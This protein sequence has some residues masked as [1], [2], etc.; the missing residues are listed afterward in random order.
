MIRNLA[1]PKFSLD[2][3]CE[4]VMW[5][6]SNLSH[7]E[8]LWSFVESSALSSWVSFFQTWEWLSVMPS[9]SLHHSIQ[10]VYTGS[11]GVWSTKLITNGRSGFHAHTIEWSVYERHEKAVENKIGMTP[12]G[13]RSPAMFEV[14]ATKYDVCNYLMFF[15]LSLARPHSP[16]TRTGRMND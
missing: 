13:M 11:L 14:V 6:Y 1:K 5:N 10:T 15:S 2:D 12:F 16:C 4:Q 7:S 8:C 9:W 3:P